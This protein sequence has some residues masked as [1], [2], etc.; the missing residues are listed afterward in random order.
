MVPPTHM[1]DETGRL[2]PISPPVQLDEVEPLI[3]FWW[4]THPKGDDVSLFRYDTPAPVNGFTGFWVFSMSNYLRS[5]HVPEI[6]LEMPIA[7]RR[8]QWL[9]RLFR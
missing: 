8:L 9:S 1:D 2:A 5:L 4:A 6:N 3:C 7:A